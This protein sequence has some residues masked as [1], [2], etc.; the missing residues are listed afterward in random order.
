MTDLQY[1]EDDVAPDQGSADP[2]A[3]AS[4]SPTDD[5]Y[6]RVRRLTIAQ[7][8]VLAD[9]RYA[10][11]FQ[12][13]ISYCNQA[14]YDIARRMGVDLAPFESQ[15]GTAALANVQAQQL[16]AAAARPGSGWRK[17]GQGEAQGYANQGRMVVMGWVD[18]TGGHGH[19]VTV[20]PDSKGDAHNPTMAQVGGNGNGRKTLGWAIS[21]KKWPNVGTYV[22]EGN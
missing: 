11:N 22:Y 20:M 7:K 14:T 9:R 5:P 2:D 8:A 1:D 4:T 15:P 12:K 6:E 19:T 17:I 21:S 3:N 10:P 16:A 13:G 18:P